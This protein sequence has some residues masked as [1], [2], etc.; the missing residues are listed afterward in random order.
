[1]GHRQIHIHDIFEPQVEREKL[2]LSHFLCHQKLS[3]TE[4]F[5]RFI[6]PVSFKNR[7]DFHLRPCEEPQEIGYPHRDCDDIRYHKT[8]MLDLRFLTTSSEIAREATKL[9][10]L[11]NTFS[12]YNVP[13][14]GK[15]MQIVPSH[16]L[17]YVQHLN[18][19]MPAHRE[20][21]HQSGPSFD[22]AGWTAFFSG[23]LQAKLPHLRTLSLAVH[24]QGLV[25]CWRNT[26]SR[27]F[28]DT[29]RPLR[30]LKYLRAFT[31][32]INEY[33]KHEEMHS[34]CADRTHDKKPR[35]SYWD[36]KKLR[37]VWA[38]EIREMVLGDRSDF[39]R[40]FNDDAV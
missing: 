29:F 36:R 12:F 30:K 27:E 22:V 32:V 21:V 24:L 20:F 39:K 13:I 26:A 25:T 9:I 6:K 8:E 16:L 15:W 11:T 38:E 37:Q 2:L 10:Y 1:M 40:S 3:E 31:I 17:A 23:D 18:M 4:I 19:E 34:R 5:E 33:Y 35:Y 28:M 14:L 7:I